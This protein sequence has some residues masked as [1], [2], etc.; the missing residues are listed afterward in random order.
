MSVHF[1]YSSSTGVQSFQYVNF[2]VSFCD[3]R[4]LICK[5]ITKIHQMYQMYIKCTWYLTLLVYSLHTL[6]DGMPSSLHFFFFFSPDFSPDS[7]QT[8]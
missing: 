1:H 4:R 7:L 6:Q 3:R 5:F 8:T 2:H